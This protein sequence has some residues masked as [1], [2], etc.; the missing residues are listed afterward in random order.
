M[1]SDP[2]AQFFSCFRRPWRRTHTK[3]NP[4]FSISSVFLSRRAPQRFFFP[5]RAK[6]LV[7]GRILR[8]IQHSLLRFFPP[9]DLIAKPRRQRHVTKFVD[10]HGRLMGCFGNNRNQV[11]VRSLDFFPNVIPLPA[12][13]VTSFGFDE[14]NVFLSL[15]CFMLGV[16]LHSPAIW[17]TVVG[18]VYFYFRN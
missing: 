7:I 13:V 15:Q 12:P 11:C 2:R 17:F 6:T 1:G 10:L 9:G 16:H 14:A 4:L 3:L 8:P 18:I 5:Y